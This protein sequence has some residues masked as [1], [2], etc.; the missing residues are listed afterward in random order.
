MK[1]PSVVLV[2][3][4]EGALGSAVVD[5]FAKAGVTV[6]ATFLNEKR[7]EWSSSKN[8]VPTQ[9][10]VTDPVSV[11]KALTAKAEYPVDAWIHCAGGFR[12]TMTDQYQDKDL[13]FLFNLNL[14]SA[15]VLA[16][17]LVPGMK[18]RNFGRIVFIGA[19]A[20]QS[21]GAG[22]G[23]YA[24]S[25]AGINSVTEALAAETKGFDINVNA[26]LPTILDTPAN[27]ADMPKADFATWVKPEALADI[28]FSLTQ[29]LSQP[30]HGALIPVAGRV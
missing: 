28:L 1:T 12:F 26:V 20:T 23:L 15:F 22:M 4:A 3:G 18:K 11:R 6:L 29:P 5:R 25:K 21:P 27:R 14:K 30:V 17:E 2:T 16:R 13:D 8:V 10:D 19:R 24:A 9:M 7:A